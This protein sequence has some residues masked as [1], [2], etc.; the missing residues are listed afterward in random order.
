[1]ALDNLDDKFLV[2]EQISS[3]QQRDTAKIT[4]PWIDAI[5]WLFC[6][7]VPMFMAYNGGATAATVDTIQ[8][9]NAWS[10]TGIGL[11]GAMDK[12]GMTVSAAVW[13]FVLQKVPAKTLLT[14]GLGVNATSVMIFATLE[15]CWLMYAAKLAIG[16]TEG[17]QWVWAPLWIARWANEEKLPLWVNLS[18]C[19]AAGVGSGLGTLLAGF[20]TAHG[21]SYGFAFKIEAGVLFILLIALVCTGEKRLA[22]SSMGAEATAQAVKTEIKDHVIRIRSASDASEFDFD[23]RSTNRGRIRSDSFMTPLTMVAEDKGL[24]EQLQIL[25]RNALFCRTTLTFASSNFV[26][27]GIAFIWIRVFVDLWSMDKQIAVVSFLVVTGAGGATGISVS[28]SLEGGDAQ[29]TLEFLRKALLVASL[30]AAVAIAGLILQLLSGAGLWCLV[31]TW[32]GIFITCAG[33]GATTGLI[34]IVCNA[35]VEDET[36]RSFG[37][38][39]SQGMNNFLGYAMGPL[40]PQVVMDIVIIIFGWNE[41]KALIAGFVSVLSGTVIAAICT[42]RALALFPASQGYHDLL[43]A[44]TEESELGSLT[45]ASPPL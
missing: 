42:T 39:L 18:G 34:Q 13:G 40:F 44:I 1:M 20:S 29:R 12:I 36:V 2:P 45:P 30:G 16:L 11:L 24:N 21:L 19:V 37:T 35:S 8:K 38:G 25:W 26:N 3:V 5:F 28:S 27:A 41:S 31:P 6:M 14:F 33:L 15:N 17:L 9:E 7:F 22:M 43:P 10:Q 4:D 32:G 23:N